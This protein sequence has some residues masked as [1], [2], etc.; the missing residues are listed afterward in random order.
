MSMLTPNSCSRAATRLRCPMESQPSTL[1]GEDVASR[2]LAST[3][4][5]RARTSS[6]VRIE[7]GPADLYGDPG[8]IVDARGARIEAPGLC[9]V[10]LAIELEAVT[11]VEVRG[12]AVLLRGDE[13]TDEPGSIL[14]ARCV[15][16]ALEQH[17]LG[18]QSHG[19]AAE[20]HAV[21]APGLRLLDRN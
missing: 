10:T 2:P 15:V 6:I 11:A 3:P 19:A 7:S 17:G 12:G 20:Q 21:D 13:L 16:D 8:W 5:T 18:R 4:K 14:G 9:A 1:S